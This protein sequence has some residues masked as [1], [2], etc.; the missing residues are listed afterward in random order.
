MAR[1]DQLRVELTDGR[2]QATITS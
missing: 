1:S 2:G